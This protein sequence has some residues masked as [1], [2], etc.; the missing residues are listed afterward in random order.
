MLLNHPLPDQVD[1]SVLP[2][3]STRKL[4]QS[5]SQNDLP[6]PSVHSLPFLIPRPGQTSSS[7]VIQPSEDCSL[8]PFPS[9]QHFPYPACQSRPLDLNPK[10]ANQPE[11]RPAHAR[12]GSCSETVQGIDIPSWS[13]SVCS[14]H[15]PHYS[16]PVLV[17][18]SEPGWESGIVLDSLVSAN[19]RRTCTEADRDVV[20]EACSIP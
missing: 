11:P 8:V 17:P 15:I 10:V 14:Q 19:P 18:A 6:D 20:S 7:E 13:C 5:R 4:H 3:P 9:L 2:A 16:V 1:W 12:W